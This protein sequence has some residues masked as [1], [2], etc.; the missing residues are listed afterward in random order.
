MSP[1]TLTRALSVAL[2]AL[3]FVG[4][5]A[6]WVATDVVTGLSSATEVVS[7]SADVLDESIDTADT[8]LAS[9][10]E[11]LEGAD[12]IVADISESTDLTA[13]VID[14]ASLLLSSEVADSV[15][16]I[17]RALPGLIEAGRVIDNTLST[18]QFFG[19]SYETDVPFAGALAEVE[20]SIS[21]LGDELRRQGRGLGELSGPVREAGQETAAL[22]T[23]LSDVQI[24]LDDARS[25]LTEYRASSAGL[26][27]VAATASVDS[28]LLAMLGRMF[29]VTWAVVC[30][31]GAVTVGRRSG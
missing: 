19:V 25:Q 28:D 21:G 23:V 30:S 13:D 6:I 20:G 3:S 9:I 31:I 26:R 22:A 10:G 11:G 8:V 29:A 1:S 2:I 5:A 15:E 14:D 12:L 4:G 24:A 16:S 17:E 27:D 18:L 7:E